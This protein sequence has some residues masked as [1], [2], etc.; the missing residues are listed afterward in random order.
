M[1]S[2]VINDAYVLAQVRAFLLQFIVGPGASEVIGDV[3]NRVSMSKNQYIV[4]NHLGKTRLSTNNDIYNL[5]SSSINYNYRY[6]LQLDCVGSNAGDWANTVAALWFDPFT[7]DFFSAFGM[8]PLWAE[9]SRHAPWKNGEGQWESR[10]IV[11]VFLQVNSSYQIPTQVFGG[12]VEIGI[13]AVDGG[14]P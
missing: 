1:I 7:C 8:A 11:N 3:D 2:T 13:V 6:G 9:D 14:N 4:M 12:P 10:W 5:E